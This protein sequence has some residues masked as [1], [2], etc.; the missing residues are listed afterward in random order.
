MIGTTLGDIRSHIEALASEDGSYVLVCARYGDRPVPA[1]DLRFETRATAR[2]AARATAQYR[3]ALRRYDPRLPRYDVIVCQDGPGGPR[4]RGTST[5]GATAG[6]D[7]PE[8]G[9]HPVGPEGGGGLAAGDAD[10]RGGRP[11]RIEFC[12]RVAA[13]VFEALSAAGHDD[14]ESAVVDAYLDLAERVPDL[15]DLCL[16]LL[17]CMAAELERRL[18]PGEQA[19]VVD[20]AAAHLPDPA[21]ANDP[22]VATLASL[23]RRRLVGEGS[24]AA[25]VAPGEA[26][27]GETVV[28]LADYALTSRE[29][30]LPTLPFAVELARREPVTT[31]ASL[32]A[33]DADDGWRLRVERA[34][35]ATPAGLASARIH[36]EEP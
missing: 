34:R 20:L 1:A 2:L 27:A 23:E 15:D 36:T 16:C 21:G 6:G 4:Q 26:G 5:E 24:R 13:A 33:F 14:V 10:S 19:R 17:E 8:A 32:D 9:D 3:A 25:P 35:G 7:R 28:R 22:I 31:L 11:T 18:A 29:G 30:R 12:H